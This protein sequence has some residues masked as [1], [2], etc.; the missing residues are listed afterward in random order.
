MTD[1]ITG[2][3]TEL[4]K[5]YQRIDIDD[6]DSV[7]SD[8]KVVEPNLVQ[9]IPLQAAPAIV[10]QPHLQQPVQVNTKPVPKT[11]RSN[12]QRFKLVVKNIVNMIIIL[13]IL[14][15]IGVLIYLTLVRYY[16]AGANLFNGNKIIGAALLSPELSTGL[17]TLALA[18]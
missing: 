17:S 15:L 3:E 8:V 6:S 5:G 9:Q 7:Q 2:I 1:L 13:L 18:L 16:L 11:Q 14:L 4:S 12:N 10:P